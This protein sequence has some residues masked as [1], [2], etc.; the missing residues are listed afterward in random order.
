MS[1]LSTSFQRYEHEST[2]AL[3]K[4]CKAI[5]QELTIAEDRNEF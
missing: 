1:L 3:F 4:L 5:N 2:I